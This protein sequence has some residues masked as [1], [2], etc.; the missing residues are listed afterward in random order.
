M[1]E[2][3]PGSPIDISP[4]GRYLAV[5]PDTPDDPLRLDIVRTDTG[6]LVS[7]YTKT[8][9]PRMTGVIGFSPDGSKFAIDSDIY[10]EAGG[11]VVILDLS[12]GSTTV[13][14]TCTAGASWLD[15]SH[16]AVGDANA[17]KAPAGSSV[18]VVTVDSGVV[19][20]S[21]GSV[22]SVDANPADPQEI[23]TVTIR[24]ASGREEAID[25]DGSFAGASLSWS[26]DGSVLLVQYQGLETVTPPEYFVMLRP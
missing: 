13:F 22:A 4:D 17:C 2:R 21:K 8:S 1:G 15:G 6:A 11:P 25:L 9:G 14:A 5:H 23:M 20:S 7:S 10:A 24:D 12:S 16:L 18:T 3:R 19:T 26:A